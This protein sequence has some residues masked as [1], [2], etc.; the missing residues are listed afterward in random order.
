[1]FMKYKLDESGF[2][3]VS[4]ILDAKELEVLRKAVD[5]VH[6]VQVEEIGTAIAPGSRRVMSRV[7]EIWTL[8]HS[9]KILSMLARVSGLDR[10]RRSYFPVR[11]LYFDK[12]EGANWTVPWHQDVSIEVD[13][14]LEVPGFG[15]WS[16]KQGNTFVTPPDDILKSMVTVRLHLDDCDAT[17]GALQIIPGSH[18]W[19]RL[20]P[21]RIT[22]MKNRQPGMVCWCQSGDALVM[23]P[24]VVHSS[25]PSQV[26]SHRRVIH[27]EYANCALPM[28]L[29]WAEAA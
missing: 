3:T 23:R 4:S 2:E 20:T 24:L 6:G 18:R 1:M 8:A 26:M 7:P 13:K 12:T 15:P 11:S 16:I 14:H 28:G 9:E 10:Q 5:S 29:H 25:L 17:N 21:E 27:L 19:G 22:E